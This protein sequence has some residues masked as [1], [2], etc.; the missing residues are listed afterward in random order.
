MWRKYQ[1][2]IVKEKI[3]IIEPME[4]KWDIEQSCI[5]DAIQNKTDKIEY[6][7]FPLKI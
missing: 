3:E 4:I 1:V 7:R 5:D 6:V 2:S